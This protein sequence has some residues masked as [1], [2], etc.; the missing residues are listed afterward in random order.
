MSIYNKSRTTAH[1]LLSSTL[2]LFF[3]R[4]GGA[5]E[6]RQQEV[7]AERVRKHDEQAEGQEEE[8][9]HDEAQD[10]NQGQEVIQGEADRTEE[11]PSQTAEI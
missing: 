9:L 6:V 2:S 4:S 8:L 1:W 11:T 5:G 7:Q 10:Q 3:S